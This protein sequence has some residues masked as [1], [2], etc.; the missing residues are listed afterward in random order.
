[1]DGNEDHFVALRWYA[2]V[3]RIPDGAVLE[4]PCLQLAPEQRMDSYSILPVEC[5][6][7]G[8]VLI[9]LNGVC[10][11][12]QSPREEVEYARNKEGFEM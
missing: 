2:E 3:Q 6:I 8:A 9:E 5:I 12:V 4:M 10:W 1:M 7:N 11:A